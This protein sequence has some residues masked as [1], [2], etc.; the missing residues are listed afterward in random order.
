MSTSLQLLHLLEQTDSTAVKLEMQTLRQ[1][2]WF[3]CCHCKWSLN[4]KS[5][6]LQTILNH[7][8]RLAALIRKLCFQTFL[9]VR[10]LCFW[11]FSSTSLHHIIISV[12]KRRNLVFSIWLKMLKNSI[13][14]ANKY[15]VNFTKNW[16]ETSHLFWLKMKFWEKW[17][18]FLCLSKK[19]FKFSS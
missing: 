14:C 19:L 15:L 16:K 13:Y 9:S 1:K 3:K 17:I 4:Q 7:I 11:A 5:D 18:M 12:L 2:I 8:K 10:K 6:W